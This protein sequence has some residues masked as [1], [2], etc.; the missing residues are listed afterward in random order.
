MLVESSP[1]LYKI[2]HSGFGLLLID[3]KWVKYN[4]IFFKCML[5]CFEYYNVIPQVISVQRSFGLYGA[6]GM[7]L[8]YTVVY[9]THYLVSGWTWQYYYFQQRERSERYVPCR[10]IVDRIGWSVIETHYIH[11][12]CIQ[13]LFTLYYPNIRPQMYNTKIQE[14]IQFIKY[15]AFIIFISF[16]NYRNKSRF[17]HKIIQI[18]FKLLK[19]AIM[20]LNNTS[21]TNSNLGF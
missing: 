3:T 2:I 4:Q 14:F 16:N 17:L 7:Q 21:F 6:L 5:M 19:N 1:N 15:R 20:F 9:L 18:F 12:L 11:L 13:Y 8:W 10:F